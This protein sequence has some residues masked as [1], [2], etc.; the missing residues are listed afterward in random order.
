MRSKQSDGGK[1]PRLRFPEFRDAAEWEEKKLKDF[2][3]EQSRIIAKPAMTYTGLGIRSHGKGTF[4]KEEQ[5]PQKNS[6]ENLFRVENNDLIVNITFAWEGAIAIA[7]DYDHGALVSHRFPT[8][9]NDKSISVI[10]FFRYVIS[11]KFFIHNLYLIS[12]GG[13]GRNRVMNK[14][15]FLEIKISIP[16]RLEQQKIADCLTSLDELIVAYNKKL[17]TLKLH[18]KGLMQQLFPAEGEIVPRLRFSEYP[19]GLEW[20]IKLLG[21]I[22]EI[23][24]GKRIPKGCI[25]TEKNTG[26]PYVRVSDMYMGGVDEKSVLYITDDIEKRI[27]NYKISKRDLFLTVAGTIGIVGKIPE[28]LDNANLTENADRIIVRE[29]DKDFLFHFL[30][31]DR[32]QKNIT[33][34]ITNNAQPK[35]A[36][37]RIRKFMIPVPS[38][39]EQQKIGV[40]LSSIDNL[41]AAQS[42]KIDALKEHKKGLMQQLFPSAKGEG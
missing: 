3:L 30:S 35:L 38:K 16:K 11:T 4:L 37:E 22:C 15:D 6:M 20:S 27:E 24:G 29:I 14:K 17:N 26:F 12:P 10:D 2:F 1:V 5:D 25:L 31:S 33:A 28:K 36:L 13:A 18:K 39:I 40:F 8:Y 41:V 34:S 9:V 19:D 7:N 42:A 21:E 23:K 32:Q